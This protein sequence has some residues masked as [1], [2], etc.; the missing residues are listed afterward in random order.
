MKSKF[1]LFCKVEEWYYSDCWFEDKYFLFE[2]EDGMNKFIE[3]KAIEVIN[4]IKIL[5][6]E[7]M[8]K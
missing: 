5:D 1:L 3:T 8:S 6:Y 7:V 2:T 4:V